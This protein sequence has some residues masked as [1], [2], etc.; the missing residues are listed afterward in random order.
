MSKNKIIRFNYFYLMTDEEDKKPKKY[1]INDLIEK[2]RVAYQ[3]GE[4]E[5]KKIDKRKYSNKEYDEIVEE[6]RKF[7]H[8]MEYKGE[9]VRLILIDKHENNTDYH[10]VFELLDYQLPELTKEYGL[11]R[12]IAAEDDE[13]I[14][15]KISCLYDSFNQVIIIQYNIN[16]LSVKAV[17][18]FINKMIS[19]YNFSSIPLKLHLITEKDVKNKILNQSMYR[20]INMRF[21]GEEAKHWIGDVFKKVDTGAYTI[22]IKISSGTRKKDKLD[23]EFSKDIIK[24]FVEKIINEDE[25]T[26]NIEKFKVKARQEEQERIQEMDLISQ[27]VQT[28]LP[29]D[30]SKQRIMKQSRIFDEMINFYRNQDRPFVNKV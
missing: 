24:G 14:G 3:S 21:S 6:K 26:K 27:K 23:E 2:M 16:S 12:V 8:V 20:S 19:N 30:I 7:M 15:H 25:N 11:P 29:I 9:K 5:I 4:E 28:L 22:E 10:L 1:E 17:E 18:L 13:Y